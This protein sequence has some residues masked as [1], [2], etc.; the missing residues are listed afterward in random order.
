V[1]NPTLTE[2]VRGLERSVVTLELQIKGIDVCQ[3]TDKQLAG[4]V[5]RLTV[6]LAVLREKLAALEKTTTDK[7]TA[8]EKLTDQIVARR[9]TI[10]VALISACAGG[11]LTFVIQLSL[12]FLAK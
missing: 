4:D 5:T 8:L 2:L 6:E 3:A 9:W 1:P 7:V 10:L 12:K 11:L